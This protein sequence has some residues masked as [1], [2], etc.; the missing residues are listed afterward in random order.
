MKP[1]L[2]ITSVR[3]TAHWQQ[4]FIKRMHYEQYRQ[5]VWEAE[6][7]EEEEDALEQKISR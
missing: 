1:Y 3:R 2:G 4:G 7:E 6:A 5:G